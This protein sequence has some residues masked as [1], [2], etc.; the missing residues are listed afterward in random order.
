MRVL[1]LWLVL[2]ST[3]AQA[4]VETYEFENEALR[5]RYHTFVDEL[6]CP[7][8]QNQNL[9][10]SN[11]PIAEDLRRELHRLLQE[12]RS[13]QQIVEFMV[14]RY[15][16]FILY[17]PRFNLETAVL[18]LAPA[19]FLLLG[20]IAITLVFLRQKRSASTSDEGQTLD[21]AEQLRLHNLLI[22]DPEKD[23]RNA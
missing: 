23:D 13:D 18:W 16:D 3:L 15:G 7:K 19:I 20:I 8:C 9:A 11:S 1:L 4:V 12:G 2:A 22:T 17:R 14:S 5:G 21:E 10:G 6:R